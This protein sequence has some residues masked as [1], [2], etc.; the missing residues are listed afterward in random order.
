M[1]QEVTGIVCLRDCR[2]TTKTCDTQVIATKE[3]S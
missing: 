3:V 1:K 2:I